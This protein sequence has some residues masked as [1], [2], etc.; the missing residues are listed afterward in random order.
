[1]SWVSGKY[2]GRGIVREN[3]AACWEG[4]RMVESILL[5]DRMADPMRMPSLSLIKIW[6]EL[7]W[8]MPYHP[9]FH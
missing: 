8:L 6:W 2:L 5:G 7:E 4:W 9:I 3:R 1:M